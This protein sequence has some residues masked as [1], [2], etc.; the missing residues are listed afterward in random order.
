[1]KR[2]NRAA[3]AQP[4]DVR[5]RRLLAFVPGAEFQSIL[6]SATQLFSPTP[7]RNITFTTT[8]II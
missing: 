6:S 7:E 1:V 4:A 3:L 8:I 5:C 2:A